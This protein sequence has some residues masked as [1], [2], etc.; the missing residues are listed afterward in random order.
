ARRGRPGGHRQADRRP[1]P[2]LL[3]RAPPAG[4]TA[5][6]R[7]PLRASPS[8]RPQKCRGSRRSPN[9]PEHRTETPPQTPA[10]SITGGA[11]GPVT[12]DE[13]FSPGWGR[14]LRDRGPSRRGRGRARPSGRAR[15]RRR[16]AACGRARGGDGGRVRADRARARAARVHRRRERRPDRA[17]AQSASRA[18]RRAHAPPPSGPDTPGDRPLREVVQPP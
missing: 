2:R 15:P 17:Y 11:R 4:A 8:R 6:L 1:Q 9:R 5:M 3:A 13:S 12:G 16:S 10:A 14:V 18:G 7:V